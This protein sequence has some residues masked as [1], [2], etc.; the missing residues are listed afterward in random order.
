MPERMV[1][2]LSAVVLSMVLASW[3]SPAAAEVGDESKTV[4]GITFYMGILPSEMVVG[5]PKEH[6]ESSMHGGARV[7]SSRYHIVVA[8]FDQASGRRITDAEVHARVTPLGMA[9]EEKVLESM[10]IGEAL[11]FGNYF[12]MSGKGP[13]RIAIRV[14][15]PDATGQVEAVFEHRH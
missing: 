9:G 10:P 15:R 1:Q 12:T 3:I 8:L 13:F 5:H 11:S 6:P 4:G 7:R 14:R 2:Y